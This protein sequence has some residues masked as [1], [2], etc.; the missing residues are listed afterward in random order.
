MSVHRIGTIE[1][2]R[3]RTIVLIEIIHVERNIEKIKNAT[4]SNVLYRFFVGQLSL[5]GKS[6]GTFDPFQFARDRWYVDRQMRKAST[7]SCRKLYAQT[8]VFPRIPPSHRESIFT[9]RNLSTN[10][11]NQESLLSID[12]KLSSYLLFVIAIENV[13]RFVLSPSLPIF[14]SR[15][16]KSREIFYSI[17]LDVSQFTI[18]PH[19]DIDILP[20]DVRKYYIDNCRYQ[21]IPIYTCTDIRMI[22]D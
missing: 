12:R 6:G 11:D 5:L 3:S 13:N 4:T 19:F 18:E 22:N 15:R 7:K 14:L 21:R 9:T 8:L 16:D 17:P 1:S 10:N 2:F 20:T